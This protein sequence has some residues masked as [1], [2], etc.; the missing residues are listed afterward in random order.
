MAESSSIMPS[1][2]RIGVFG[3]GIVAPKSPTVD[4]FADNLAAGG[5]WLEPFNGFGPDNFLVGRPA[6]DFHDYK[7]WIDARFPP[8]R[9]PQPENPLLPADH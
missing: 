1:R 9:Y 8:G 2:R 5:S 7:P 4:A 6:F 3:W